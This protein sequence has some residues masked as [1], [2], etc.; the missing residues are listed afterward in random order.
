MQETPEMQ[1]QSL[2]Q[3]DQVEEGM[4]P[5]LVFLTG[6]SHGQESLGSQELDTIKLLS[7]HIDLKN[8]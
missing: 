5:T 6:K 1:V 7:Y 8:K 4:E 2:A 3:E